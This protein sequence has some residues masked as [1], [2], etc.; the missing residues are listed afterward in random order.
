MTPDLTVIP[1]G[2]GDTPPNEQ[3]TLE[4]LEENFWDARDEL[5][6]IY[7]TALSRMCSPWAVLAICTAR[8]LS[9]VPSSIELPNIIGPGSLN[10]FAVISAKSGGG[11]SA[12]MAVA[13]RL[14]GGYVNVRNV[15][16]GE[17]MI[18]C[19]QRGESKGKEAPPEVESVLFS[20]DEISSLGAMNNRAGQTTMSIIKSGFSGNDLGYSYRGRQSEIVAARSYR[21]TLV[22]AV[23]PELAGVLFD[24]T[25]GGTPQRFMWFPGR[26]K[27][28]TA[29]TPEW[30]TDDRGERT[31]QL[32]SY[33]E[34]LE[35]NRIIRIP[36][37][38]VREI[39]ETR[40]ASMAGDDNA[41][42]SHALFCREKFAYALA[43]MDS[44]FVISEDDWKLSFIAGAVS[45]WCRTKSQEGYQAG[46]RRQSRDRGALR[47][48]ENDERTLVETAVRE[49]HITRISLWIK[50]TLTDQGPLSRG[51]LNIKVAARDRPRLDSALD[52]ARNMRWITQS[53]ESGKWE[54]L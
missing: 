40:A 51:A 39:R 45:D 44:R 4:E 30:P 27:R 25:G 8:I 9:R 43:M 5:R 48:I 37:V 13:E 53:D 52:E 22:V 54:V 18:E 31:L 46:K 14:V 42:D 24:D 28:I 34:L 49:K 7:Q 41:L 38:A 29:D 33:D 6:L 50:K 1:G 3:R 47:G 36:D 20:I 19:Y 32:P 23:Q 17:G 2:A 21:M 26:D 35:A 15:G 10:W 16:S 11:K 12:A